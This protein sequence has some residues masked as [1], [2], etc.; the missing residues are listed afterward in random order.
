MLSALPPPFTIHARTQ[1]MYEVRVPADCKGSE[2]TDHEIT[3][4]VLV[5][6]EAP[7]NCTKNQNE[8]VTTSPFVRARWGTPQTE[9]TQPPV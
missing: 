8:Q 2:C 4:S 1:V 6:A 9:R 5:D 3:N 7:T